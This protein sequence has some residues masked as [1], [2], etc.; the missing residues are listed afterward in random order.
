MP[1]QGFKLTKKAVQ[2]ISTIWNYTF[3]KWSK[4]QADKYYKE[5]IQ[6]CRKLSKNPTIGRN[7]FEVMDA[8]KGSKINRHII[9][10]RTLESDVIE[11]ERILHERM[12]LKKH[13]GE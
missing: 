6:H 4:T 5:I 8:L 2:D 3:D 12:D 10:Y 11:I 9:F 1:N 13:L 7:Y